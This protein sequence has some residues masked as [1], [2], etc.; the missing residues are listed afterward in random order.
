MKKRKK[1]EKK[2]TMIPPYSTLETLGVQESILLCQNNCFTQVTFQHIRIQT[3]SGD[4][5]G[6]GDGSDND[7]SDDGGGGDSSDGGDGGGGDGSGGGDDD[8][9]EGGGDGGG[10]DGGGDGGIKIDVE[11]KQN[12]KEPVIIC[13]KTA[14]DQGKEKKDKQK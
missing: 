11:R 13:R 1:K 5:S 2:P 4:D 9:S 3:V 6:G 7:D 14:I 10:S 8:G 12:Q